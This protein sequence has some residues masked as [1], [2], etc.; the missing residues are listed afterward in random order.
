[1]YDSNIVKRLIIKTRAGETLTSQEEKYLRGAI[2]YSK[3]GTYESFARIIFE[4]F[5]FQDFHGPMMARINDFINTP[6][7]RLVITAPPQHGKTLFAGFGLCAYIFGRFPEY[8]VLYLTY[9]EDRAMEAGTSFLKII[10]SD[11]YLDLFP[12][13]RVQSTSDEEHDTITKKTRKQSRKIFNNVNSKR[14]GI[15]FHSLG[16]GYQGNPGHIIIVDDP[17]GRLDDARSLVYRNKQWDGLYGNTL[18]RLQRGARV[19]L[20]NTHWHPDDLVGRLRKA[21]PYYEENDLNPWEFI[22]LPAIATEHAPPNPKYDKRTELWD[23]DIKNLKDEMLLWPGYRHKYIEAASNQDVFNCMYQG[24]PSEYDGVIFTRDMFRTYYTVPENM[25]SIIISVDTN[26]KKGIGKGSKCGICVFGIK[27][28]SVYLLEFLNKAL[29]YTETKDVVCDLAAKYPRYWAI[30]VEE[31]ANGYALLEDLKRSF[32]RLDPYNPGN[33]SKMQRAQ[34]TLPIIQDGLYIPAKSLCQKV[35]IYLNQML[36][37]TG[38]DKEENDLVDATSQAVLKYID[39]FR[40]SGQHKITTMRSG[41]AKMFGNP[42]DALKQ[43][44][45]LNG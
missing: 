23:G 1:M 27:G 6:D 14:G 43:L 3:I 10:S 36:A 2:Q 12:E 34:A 29:T 13:A 19:M 4:G 9:N 15:R 8:S 18:T 30:R 44:G 39:Y 7:D 33:Q 17:I 31:K 45:F 32:A 38:S 11:E 5:E 20:C 42:S 22:N 21:N 40:M 35:D 37:F 16:E 26:F 41:Y 28:R 24:V 25:T